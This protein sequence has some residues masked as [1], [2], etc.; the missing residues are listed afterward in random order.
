MMERRGGAGGVNRE[1]VLHSARCL[2][3][4]QRKPTAVAEATGDATGEG[5]RPVVISL[6]SNLAFISSLFSHTDRRLKCCKFISPLQTRTNHTL[7]L[8]ISDSTLKRSQSAHVLL[9]AAERRGESETRRGTWN[10]N[11][12]VSA[13]PSATG[14]CSS[15][16]GSH[17]SNSWSVCG[18]RWISDPHWASVSL[19]NL[20]ETLEYFCNTLRLLQTAHDRE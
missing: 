5:N 1:E 19:T 11:R 17:E 12:L 20:K 8:N 6:Q 7:H 15:T 13:L 9:A 3:W 18:P 16:C 2:M 14:R 4:G 10:L